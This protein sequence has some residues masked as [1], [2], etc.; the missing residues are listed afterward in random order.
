MC[1][2]H[3]QCTLHRVKGKCRVI[4]VFVVTHLEECTYVV[5]IQFLDHENLPVTYNASILQ[6]CDSPVDV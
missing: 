2:Q 4:C 6:S 5:V 3:T 1:T